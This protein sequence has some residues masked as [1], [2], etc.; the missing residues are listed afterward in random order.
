MIK[1]ERIEYEKLKVVTQ[2]V[3]DQFRAIQLLKDMFLEQFNVI[4]NNYNKGKITCEITIPEDHAAIFSFE[5]MRVMD[6]HSLHGYIEFTD[7]PIA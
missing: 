5:M 4:T 7:L 6:E 1:I 2:S 3:Q